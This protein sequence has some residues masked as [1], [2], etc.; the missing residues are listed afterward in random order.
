M[1]KSDWLEC[2]A[3]NTVTFCD[4]DEE[5]KELPWNK[6][7]KFKGVY[8][9]HLITSK[10]TEGKLSCH[11]VRIDPQCVLEEHVHESQWETH[12]IIGGSGFLVLAG[13]E[14]PF[15]PGR[16]AVIPK[17]MTH[18]VVASSEGLVLLAHFSPAL[19]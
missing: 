6:H 18:S 2:I 8:L 5:I 12:E 4:R 1:E 3:N 19:V 9:K 14:T 16:V 10:D 17:G 13:R 15:H 11:M 7:P